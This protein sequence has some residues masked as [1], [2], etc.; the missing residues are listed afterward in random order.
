MLITNN[1]KE[2][3]GNPIASFFI[4]QFSVY[5][6]IP[7]GKTTGLSNPSLAIDEIPKK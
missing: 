4:L 6:I 5:L 2:A 1:R 7:L 3:I